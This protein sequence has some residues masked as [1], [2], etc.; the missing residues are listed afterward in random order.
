MLVP[1][2]PSACR[3]KEQAY[4]QL[5]GMG[6]SKAQK[7]EDK[8]ERTWQW[9]TSS[10]DP[11]C[12]WYLFQYELIFYFISF[13]QDHND[14]GERCCLHCCLLLSPYSC[15]YHLLDRFNQKERF[16]IA[17]NGREL[18]GWSRVS[19]P[20]LNFSTVKNPHDTGKAVVVAY[21]IR[22]R[23]WRRRKSRNNAST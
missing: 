11:T 17:I 19:L 10:L 6:H 15:P 7:S 16:S 21:K 3:E 9:L 18:N 20:S 22:T 1:Q 12:S 5:P 14:D 23:R 4:T 13:L 2:W 8:S